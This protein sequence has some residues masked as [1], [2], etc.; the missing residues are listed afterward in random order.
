MSERGKCGI[1]EKII[2]ERLEEEGKEEDLN[3]PH[4]EMGLPF[5]KKNEKE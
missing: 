4:L 3:V 2:N 5:K 1:S